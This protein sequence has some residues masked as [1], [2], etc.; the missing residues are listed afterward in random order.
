MDTI[1]N[2]ADMKLI[3]ETETLVLYGDNI[4]EDNHNLI[5]EERTVFLTNC[6][7]RLMLCTIDTKRDHD[8][9]L[10][11]SDKNMLIDLLSQISSC[12]AVIFCRSGSCYTTFKNIPRQYIDQ[13]KELMEKTFLA[14]ILQK[15]ISEEFGN[16]QI[17]TTILSCGIQRE[18]SF[19]PYIQ[20]TCDTNLTLVQSLPLPYYRGFS[21]SQKISKS[22]NFLRDEVW[23]VSSKYRVMVLYM[24]PDSNPIDL[25]NI[26]GDCQHP[27]VEIEL[28][29]K[30]IEKLFPPCV[31]LD[32]SNRTVAVQGNDCYFALIS[33]NK[34]T[35]DLALKQL[36]KCLTV[37][38]S[39]NYKVV[40]S[41][42]C[43][44]Y[45][46]QLHS[47]FQNLQS[48][49]F[50]SVVSTVDRAAWATLQESQEY[51]LREYSHT[52]L[53]IL[54]CAYLEQFLQG[55][56]TGCVGKWI[57]LVGNGIW[58]KETFDCEDDAIEKGCSDPEKGYPKVVFSALVGG[59]EQEPLI[60]DLEI[61]NAQ[62][63]SPHRQL[64]IT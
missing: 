1:K 37:M 8:N 61:E 12:S 29:M 14:S 55:E 9:I 25:K 20:A 28:W 23:D 38:N 56:F 45:R 49:L 42:Q 51:T 26:Y 3:G 41:S 24:S 27:N 64:A 13:L 53:Q 57:Y 46:V 62:P 18:K 50:P 7:S 22:I 31:E 11:D 34:D 58:N 54:Q 10:L 63:N 33:F 35:H 2:T 21:M 48:K 43:P 59:K 39:S 32:S 40:H 16:H 47:K 17:A 36:S 5:P 15:V 44:P 30:G 4:E 60:P 19:L 52:R 6:I